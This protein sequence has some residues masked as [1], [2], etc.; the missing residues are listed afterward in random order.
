MGLK[1]VRVGTPK[2]RDKLLLMSAFAQALL[3][4]LGAAGESLGYDKHLK[5]NEGDASGI[6]GDSG[7]QV[8]P[9]GTL[10]LGRGA[11]AAPGEPTAPP[12]RCVV[13]FHF[14]LV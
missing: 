11:H 3:T 13:C 5:V 4:L 14:S 7:D 10:P 1:E 6:E 9:P 2:R 12:P 8:G